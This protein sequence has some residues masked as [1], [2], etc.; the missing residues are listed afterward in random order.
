MEINGMDLQD[1]T[2]E[3]LAE[4]LAGDSPKL[5]SSQVS[6]MSIFSI[7]RISSLLTV[8]SVGI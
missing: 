4:E 6:T 5:V 7:S 1:L 8:C 2:P 3:E